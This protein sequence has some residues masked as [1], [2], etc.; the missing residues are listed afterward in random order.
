MNRIK[1]WFE[2]LLYPGQRQRREEAFAL[3]QAA[4]DGLLAQ[5]ADG[6]SLDEVLPFES[7]NPPEWDRVEQA[8]VL[9]VD[10]DRPMPVGK[11]V[12]F[13]RGRG[14]AED[15]IAKIVAV[16]PTKGGTRH[17]YTLSFDGGNPWT[18]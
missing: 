3:M 10:Q 13:K 6:K 14:D 17:T 4:L 9:R 1:N 5:L 15:E 2:D 7:E 8:W 16:L 18:A 12:F 11:P